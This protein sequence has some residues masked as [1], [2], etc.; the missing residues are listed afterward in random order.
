MDETGWNGVRAALDDLDYPARKEQVVGHAERRGAPAAAMRLLR[1]L[2]LETYRN[3]DEIRSSVPLDPAA[4]DGQT[5]DERA[6]RAR[7]PHNHRIAQHL[8]DLRT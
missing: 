5:P 3:L 6:R 8:R 1:G 7:S 4:D 2:P